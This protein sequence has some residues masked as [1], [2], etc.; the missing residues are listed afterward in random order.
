MRDKG[1][2]P[3]ALRNFADD[4]SATTPI[5]RG[6]GALTIRVGGVRV[7]RVEASVEVG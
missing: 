1:D 3:F 6:K 2:D 5:V 4:R 7:G